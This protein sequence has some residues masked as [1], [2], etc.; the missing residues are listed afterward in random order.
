MGI[1]ND[2]KEAIEQIKSLESALEKAKAERKSGL[3]ELAEVREMLSAEK[4][5]IQILSI[6]VENL[7][8]KLLQSK[9]RQKSSVERANR[10][11]AQLQKM[12]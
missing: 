12:V 3:A 11:K 4:K 10:F 2:N 6:E 9:I 1:F 5:N 8:I 7:K